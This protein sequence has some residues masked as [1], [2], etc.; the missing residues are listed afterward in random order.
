MTKPTYLPPIIKGDAD[1][2][3]YRPLV[4]ENGITILLAHDPQSKNFAASVSVHAGASADPRALPGLAHFCEHMCFLGSKA[5]PEENEYKQY[6]AQHGGKSNASTSMSHTTYQF[7]VLADYGE[8]ALD[9]FS[10]FFI[11]PLFTPS[12]TQREVQAVDSENSKNLVSDGRRRLQVLKSLADEKH[13]FSKF[14][15][16]NKFTL[17]AS[18]SEGNVDS[19]LG[20]QTS[21]KKHPLEDIL[22]DINGGEYNKT[23]SAEFVRAALLAFHE[24]HYRPE[25]MTAVMIGP[26]SLDEL[27]AWV[28]PRFGQIPDRW[29]NKNDGEGKDDED[30]NDATTDNSEKWQAMK[31]AAAQ[32]VDESSADAPPISIQAAVE[33]SSAFR[34]ELQGG[35]WPVVVT[36]KPVQ[37]VRKLDLMFPLPP[38]W[39]TPDQSPT[40]LLS[41]LF[42]HEGPGSPYASLQDKG[43]ITSLSAGNRISGPDQALFQIGISL[44]ADGEKHWKEVAKVIFDYGKM[45]CSVSEASLASVGDANNDTCEN[46]ESENELRRIWDEVAALDRLRFHQTSPGGVYSFAPAVAQSISKFGAENCLSV[47]SRLNENGDTLP[48]EDTLK[49]CQR[50][51]PE[52][53]FIERSSEGAWEEMEALYEGKHSTSESSVGNGDFVFGKHTEQWYGVDYFVS[54][55]DEEDVLRW[56][57]GAGADEVALHLPKPN[58]YIPRSLEL[59]EDLPEDAKVQRIEKP[60]EP[61]KLIVNKPNGRLWWR[62]DDRYA[63]PKASVTLLLRTATAEN[64]L[65]PGADES[66]NLRWDYHGETS[67]QSNFLT[68]IFADAMAQDTYDSYLAGLGWSLSKSSSGFTLS[69]SGYSDRLSDFAIKL[70]TDFCHLDGSSDETFLKESHFITSKD[71]FVR[72]MRS[73]LESSRADSLALYYRNLLL[74]SKGDGI[75][76]NLELAE[77]MKLTDVVNQQQEIWADENMVVEMFYTGN[78]SQKEAELFFDQTM[79]IIEKTQSKVLQ[80]RAEQTKCSP[81]VPGPFERRL[82]PGEDIEL[83]FASKNPKEENGA[84]IVTYQSQV[85]G[86]KGKSLSSEESLQQSAAIRL[87][88]KM[89]KEPLFNELRT[90]QQLGYIVSSYYDVNYSSRQTDFFLTQASFPTRPPPGIFN[91][92]LARHLLILWLSMCLARKRNPV[93]LQIV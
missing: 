59:C 30:G 24:R 52:N 10:N 42:G 7:D 61:P 62:L 49:F 2:R 47:G 54:R 68:N 60:I 53:C 78:V 45:V 84:V 34:P 9:V 26:Q 66:A 69:C 93:K 87:L 5:Y 67:M 35:K 13:H 16:G 71:K 32:I 63:L 11:S 89:I 21:D 86:F 22:K 92:P 74:T 37:S 90:K 72:G 1:Y 91:Q 38:T 85:E 56:E 15:T 81:W 31:R 83:H 8:K 51:I 44:T 80:D 55:V 77:A 64:K 29:L 48:L 33:P 65:Q 39:R 17:P 18:T 75:M 70:L 79:D 28:V 3:T 41:H 4:L 76:K 20:T 25:N 46:G 36:T 82:P 19:E 40:S 43:W 27:E 6:L 12:G 50:M 57:T 58:R 14:S 23:D 73:Y 88:C